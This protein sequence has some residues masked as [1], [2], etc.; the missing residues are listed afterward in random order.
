MESKRAKLVSHVASRFY[1]HPRSLVDMNVGF[2]LRAGS[3][4]AEG[5]LYRRHTVKFIQ[6]ILILILAFVCLLGVDYL[7]LPK[8][9]AAALA[10]VLML[11]ITVLMALTLD[12]RAAFTECTDGSF[13]A[14]KG[15]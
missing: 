2:L 6:F 3:I 15:D 11:G 1:T 5:I 4:P 10:S 9:W 7:N 13:T 12:G 14:S 8:M